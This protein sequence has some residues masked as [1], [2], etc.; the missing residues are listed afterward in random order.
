MHERAAIA[1]DWRLNRSRNLLILVSCKVVTKH[2]GAVLQDH[3]DR[4]AG[5]GR[6]SLLSSA[7]Q[8][9][10][11]AEPDRQRILSSLDSSPRHAAPVRT[12]RPRARG[13]AW[14]AAAVGI[15]AVVLL[16]FVAGEGDEHG[17]PETVHVAA[18]PAGVHVAAPEPVA[19]LPAAAS[20]GA[21]SGAGTAFTAA[22]AAPRAP[23]PAA[24]GHVPPAEPVHPGAEAPSTNP[25]ADMAPT[26]AAAPAA[27]HARAP[28]VADPLTRALE[29]RQAR[30]SPASRPQ[31]EAR[32]TASAQ[33]KAAPKPRP[34]RQRAQSEPDSDVVLLAALI[35]HMEPRNRKATLGE[36]LESCKR[37][38]AA[39][40][41]QCRARVCDAA[42]RKEPAC[43]GVQGARVRPD[44]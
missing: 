26:P 33:S 5:A 43:K 17:L 36:R 40:Q 18:V 39:G 3:D 12:P 35:G 29:N 34:A 13:W 6:P 23:V 4:P 31:R 41:E 25:L 16:A 15:A 24:P 42:E 30:H 1:H 32:Q 14:G 21:A 27:K 28:A 22:A 38:N 20:A 19:A 11:Q 8:A 44:T 2:Q 37:Y 7:S 9:D 10:L